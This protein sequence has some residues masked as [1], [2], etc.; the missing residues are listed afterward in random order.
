MSEPLTITAEL[1]GPVADYLPMLDALLLAHVL[2]GQV[3]QTPTRFAPPPADEDL[4]EIPL[5]RQWIGGRLVYCVSSPIVPSVSPRMHYFGT[6]MTT[7]EAHWIAPAERKVF[8]TTGGPL[9][10]YHIPLST[11][12]VPRVVWIARGDA[13]ALRDLV[14]TIAH[15]G[16]KTAHGWGR[17]ARWTV[18]PRDDD[19]CWFARRGEDRPVLMRPLPQCDEL[20]A[21]LDGW[22]EDY[23]AVT[24]PYWHADRFCRRVVPC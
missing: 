12:A 2:R 19:A 10:S 16:R 23:G 18:V 15:L 6:R 5:D 8:L 24:P 9:K 4:P 7:D 14:S 21:D 11:M 13:D 17:V 3:Q 20:P 1:A 22:R